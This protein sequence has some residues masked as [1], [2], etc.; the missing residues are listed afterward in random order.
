MPSETVVVIGG[1]PGGL[2]AAQGIAEL[3]GKAVLIEQRGFLGGTP[4]A[5]N[6]CGLT[7]AVSLRNHRSVRWSTWSLPT[8]SSRSGSV[9]RSPRSRGSPVPSHSDCVAPNSRD[10]VEWRPD[11]RVRC[12]HHRHRLCPLRPGAGDADVR[13]LRVPRRHHP[14]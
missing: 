3:G 6:Y 5:E 13:V 14:A 12:H 4:V 2:R 11:D 10:Q 9:P 7:L 8:R 1:G